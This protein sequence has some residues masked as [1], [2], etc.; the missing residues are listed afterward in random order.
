MHPEQRIPLP[1]ATVAAATAPAAI[2]A[3]EAIAAAVS[4]KQ[5]WQEHFVRDQGCIYVFVRDLRYIW[6]EKG[7]YVKKE[8]LRKSG[9]K[10][11]RRKLKSM[12]GWRQIS[13]LEGGNYC[14]IRKSIYPYQRDRERAPRWSWRWW[15][16]TPITPPP[17]GTSGGR[18]R[19]PTYIK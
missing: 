14:F 18:N 9:R 8:G 4:L 12:R 3:A 15:R 2:V 19:T 5:L 7:K 11:N 16:S 13:F 1:P 6:G 10:M 17:S